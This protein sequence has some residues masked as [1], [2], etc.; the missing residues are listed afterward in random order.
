[1]AKRSGGGGEDIFEA[2]QDFTSKENWDKFF[3]LR[4]SGDYFEWYANWRSIEAPLLSLLSGSGGTDLRILVPG[5]GSSSVSEKLYDAGYRQITN[6]DFSKVVVSDML[7]RNV[8]SRPEMRWRVMDMTEMQFADG[9][10]DIVL[11]KGGLDALMEPGVGSKL[12][13]KY[14]KEVKRVLKL[15]G[16]YLCLTLAESHVIGLIFTK[17]RFGWET[18]ISA[19]PHEPG[20]GR[21][22][23]FLVTIVKENLDRLNPVISSF[24]ES[25]L[26]YDT[27]QVSALVSLME[28]ENKIREKTSCAHDILYNLE[29]LLLGAKGNIKELQP[30]RR[31]SLILGEQGDSLHSYKTVILDAKQQPDPFLYHC[32]VFIVPKIRAHE[33]LF[34][35]EEGQWLVVGSS[36]AARLIMIFLDSSHSLASMDDIQKDLSPLVKTVAPGEPADEAKIPFMMANDGVKQRSIVKQVTSPVT[37][38]IIVEDVVYENSN[39]DNSISTVSDAKIFRRLTFERS[40]G[41]VQSE[42]LLRKESSQMHPS[43]EEKKRSVISSKSRKKGG[44]KR[45]DSRNSP[46]GS[47]GNYEVDHTILASSYHSGI[48]CG[49][50]LIASSLESASSLRKKVKTVIIGLGAGLLPMFLHGCLPFLDIEVVELDPVIFDLAKDC[51]GFVEDKELKVHIGDGIKFIQDSNIS[52]SSKAV[53]QD[54]KRDSD[55]NA[56]DGFA[57]IKILIIDADSSDLRQFRVDLPSHRFH[58]RTIPFICQ[59]ISIRRSLCGKFSFKIYWNQRNCDFKN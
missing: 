20:G 40:S 47:S 52:G 27:A 45:S 19:M 21:F 13:S 50:A 44:K 59:E 6:I 14:L 1:M 33:W 8:R 4:G 11:D 55:A 29:D 18:S 15:G 49:F 9:S 43:E 26:D 25:F 2:L 53:V 30:G 16:K 5:C 31:C 35:S 32:G 22:Q 28:N 36:K 37:G 12:G 56:Q 34:T 54:E 42:A 57:G 7:R 17:F 10:F 41:L 39:G 24:D 48:I 23:T 51:F 58:R 38:P 46:H 3:T